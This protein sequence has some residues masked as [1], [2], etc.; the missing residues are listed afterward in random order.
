MLIFNVV[1]T[2]GTR[3]EVLIVLPLASAANMN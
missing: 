3:G 2:S 1:L